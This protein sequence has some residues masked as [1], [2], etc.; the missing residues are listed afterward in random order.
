[1]LEEETEAHSVTAE[2]L[3]NRALDLE[4]CEAELAETDLELQSVKQDRDMWQRKFND[5]TYDCMD[6]ANQ[7]A[8]VTKETDE[9]QK[10][11]VVDIPAATSIDAIS[12]SEADAPESAKKLSESEESG[13]GRCDA[14][15]SPDAASRS[16][17]TS[18]YSAESVAEAAQEFEQPKTAPFSAT[19][20]VSTMVLG[21]AAMGAG[22]WDEDEEDAT[23]VPRGFTTTIAEQPLEQPD[24]HWS[25]M[26]ID[27]ARHL[28]SVEAVTRPVFK[29]RPPQLY[30]NK[31][32]NNELL[33][34]EPLPV[35]ARTGEDFDLSPGTE[36]KL[37]INVQLPAT[38]ISQEKLITLPITSEKAISTPPINTNVTESSNTTTSVPK[39]IKADPFSSLVDFKK[40]GASS[41]TKGIKTTAIV[42]LA[43]AKESV[44]ALPSVASPDSINTNAPKATTNAV[45]VPV[46]DTAATMSTVPKKSYVPSGGMGA[47]K[48]APGSDEPTKAGGMMASK[49]AQEVDEPR[50]YKD[51]PSNTPTGPR[52]GAHAPTPPKAIA[53]GKS[54]K[55]GRGNGRSCGPNGPGGGGGNGNPPGSGGPG[56]GGPGYGGTGFNG[57][58]GVTTGY[59]GQRRRRG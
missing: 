15:P 42:Q 26:H 7:L 50:A 55:R 34:R 22:A 28:F 32:V 56:F 21:A 29:L 35:D 20:G 13:N 24:E 5:K 12:H 25:T 16:R 1:M 27:M 36:S 46:Q 33:S 51:L 52:A 59:G 54:V 53:Q 57:G 14:T 11:Q 30:I 47:S 19:V 8:A 48:Y 9:H 17:S 4:D 45:T 58:G 3:H 39:A 43:V 41:T 38:S 10:P 23:F 40:G 2:K 49:H 37:A 31:Q 6:L 18:L 44:G